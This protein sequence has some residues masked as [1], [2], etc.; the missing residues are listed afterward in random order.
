MH[1]GWGCSGEKAIEEGARWITIF[2]SPTAVRLQVKSM[3]FRFWCQIQGVMGLNPSSVSSGKC[4]AL[5]QP[6]CLTC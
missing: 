6:Q 3:C 4:L 1:G 5:F 2:P